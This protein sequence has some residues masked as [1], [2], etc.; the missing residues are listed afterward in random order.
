MDPAKMV[1]DIDYFMAH[2]DYQRATAILVDLQT[3]VTDSLNQCQQA[4]DK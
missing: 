1:D 4:T 3:W 2:G